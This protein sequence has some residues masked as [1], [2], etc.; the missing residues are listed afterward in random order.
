MPLQVVLFNLQIT[1]FYLL[2]KQEKRIMMAAGF[3]KGAYIHDSFLCA[4]H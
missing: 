3:E 1:K 4:H 2:N